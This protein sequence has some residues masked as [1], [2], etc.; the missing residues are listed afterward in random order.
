[1]MQ[2]PWPKDKY[3][4]Y[5]SRSLDEIAHILQPLIWMSDWNSDMEN[6]WE[7]YEGQ[8]HH[9]REWNIS[10][11]HLGVTDV[12]EEPVVFMAHPYPS[13]PDPMGILLANGLGETI[14]YGKALVNSED[15]FDLTSTKTYEPNQA[16]QAA[17]GQSATAE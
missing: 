16:E 13:D 7:W 8:D 2:N 14:F 10:R 12:T 5:T 15:R 17:A 11:R 9:F 3:W 1:M 4:C 6:V